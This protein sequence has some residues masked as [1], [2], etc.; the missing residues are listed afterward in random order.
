MSWN[1]FMSG[2]MTMAAVVIALFFLR[3]WRTSG[4]RLFLFFSVAFVLLGANWMLSSGHGMVVE[5][6][7]LFRFAAFVLIAV[8]I[9]NKN[10]AGSRQRG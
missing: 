4:E 9:I 3:Y 5:H 8:A 1:D 2:A 7:H 10:R 6:A